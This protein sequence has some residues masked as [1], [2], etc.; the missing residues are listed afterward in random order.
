MVWH[1][2][3]L[4]NCAP[5]IIQSRSSCRLRSSYHSC[6]VGQ[7]VHRLLVVLRLWPYCLECSTWLP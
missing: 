2:R 3:T 1:Q 7:T 5:P 6:S 4:L